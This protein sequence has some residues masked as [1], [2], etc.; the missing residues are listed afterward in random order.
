[1]VDLVDLRRRWKSPQFGQFGSLA[2]RYGKSSKGAL[3]KR[4]T[5]LLAPERDWVVRW[6]RPIG[7]PQAAA[8]HVRTVRPGAE[9]G[10]VLACRARLSLVLPDCSDAAGI[11]HGVRPAAHSRRPHPAGGRNCKACSFLDERPDHCSSCQQSADL[12][13]GRRCPRCTL[14]AKVTD[15]LL[16]DG[17]TLDASLRPLADVLSDAPNPYPVLAWPSCVEAP[18]RAS[19]A[20]LRSLPSRPTPS[21]HTWPVSVS[22]PPTSSRSTTPLAPSPS[23]GRSTRAQRRHLSGRRISTVSARSSR[24]SHAR[25]ARAASRAARTVPKSCAC[26]VSSASTSE[27]STPSSPR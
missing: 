4:R 23:H 24:H 1:M 5:V 25:R 10:R 16:R 13:P 2:V 3:P 17:T 18:P 27:S 8:A 20:S 11:V 9:G 26:A 12:L 7:G 22:H 15:L 21:L 19:W 6:G 14:L